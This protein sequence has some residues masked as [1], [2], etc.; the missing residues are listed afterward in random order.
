MEEHGHVL[1]F[2]FY[3]FLNH[4]HETSQGPVAPVE[5]VC[6]AGEIL[7]VPCGKF[8]GSEIPLLDIPLT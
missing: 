7:F 2:I 6:K 1:I 8:R 5:C 4:Y 3:R